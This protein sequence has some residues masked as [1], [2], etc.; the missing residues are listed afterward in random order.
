MNDRARLRLLR[1]S[2][3]ISRDGWD[4][5]A[6]ESKERRKGSEEAMTSAR[7]IQFPHTTPNYMTSEAELRARA[8][9]GLRAVR[10]LTGA[11]V[12]EWSSWWS[13]AIGRTITPGKVR[14]WE[15]PLGPS[16]SNHVSLCAY[17]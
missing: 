15:D 2:E 3:R 1:N 5:V 16:P 12:E 11:S 17:L 9:A 7:V 14:A 10:E 13:R 6:V 8:A 4:G